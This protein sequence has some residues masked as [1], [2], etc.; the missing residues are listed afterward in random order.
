[1]YR[2]GDLAR[3]RSDGNLDYVGRDDYQ[4]K[5]RGFRIELGEI[6]AALRECDNVADAVVVARDDPS[7]QKQLI[8]YFVPGS[9]LAPVLESLISALRD[10]LPVYMVPAML[11]P[12]PSFPLTPNGNLD[13]Q[14]PPSPDWPHAGSRPAAQPASSPVRRTIAGSGWESL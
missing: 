9:E 8:G 4:V 3:F 14:A 2:T 10:C 1:M 12:L 6:E 11:V 13:R 7:G 5:I